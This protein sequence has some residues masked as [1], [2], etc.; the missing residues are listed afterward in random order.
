MCPDRDML[1]RRY[2]ADLRVYVDAAESLGEAIGANFPEVFRRAD[3]ARMA[4]ERARSQLNE[5]TSRHYCSEDAESEQ[6]IRR[7]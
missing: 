4:F 5:H 1:F 2:H 7:D 6:A 3:R